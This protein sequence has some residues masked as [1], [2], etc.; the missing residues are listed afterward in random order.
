MKV[1]AKEMGF[2]DGA[3]VRPGTVF[4]HKGKLG[5]WME[6]A[7]AKLKADMA[8]KPQEPVALKDSKLAPK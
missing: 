5:K 6:P 4:D 2:M 3:R 8:P 1:R 7:D